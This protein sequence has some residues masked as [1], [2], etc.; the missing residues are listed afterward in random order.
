M[1]VAVVPERIWYI[2]IQDRI[3]FLFMLT[4]IAVNDILFDVNKYIIE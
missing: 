4:G 1:A 3:S 2:V